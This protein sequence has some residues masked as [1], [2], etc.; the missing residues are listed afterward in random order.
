M[1][2]ARPGAVCSDILTILVPMPRKS[3]HRKTCHRRDLR[4]VG[5]RR[6]GPRQ[7][8]DLPATVAEDVRL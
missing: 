8:R 4:G 1:A 6:A 7:Q 2:I 3:A 5:P